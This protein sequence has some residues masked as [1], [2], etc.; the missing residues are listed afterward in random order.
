MFLSKNV[1]PFYYTTKNILCKDRILIQNIDFFIKICH[2]YLFR[3]FLRKNSVRKENLIVCFLLRWRIE[4]SRTVLCLFLALFAS[5]SFSSFSANPTPEEM[6]FYW[7]GDFLEKIADVEPFETE[8][9][10]FQC[11]QV[12]MSACEELGINK[13]FGGYIFGTCLGIYTE[14]LSED[15]EEKHRAYRCMKTIHILKEAEE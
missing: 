12:D 5:M 3:L 14:P 11:M 4:M 15:R 8:Y 1:L 10:M 6:E 2:I 13:G 7:K 9:E